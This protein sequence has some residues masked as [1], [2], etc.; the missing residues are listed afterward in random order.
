MNL[1]Q[2]FADSMI[3]YMGKDEYDRLAAALDTTPPVS[4]RLN[5]SKMTADE[6]KD[7]V[8]NESHKSSMV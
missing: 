1:P 6:R 5:P 2:E 3:A 7:I 4:M 8:K